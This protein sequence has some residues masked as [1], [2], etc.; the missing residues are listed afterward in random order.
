MGRKPKVEK[1]TITVV[2]N[3]TAISVILHPPKPPRR[4]W[5]AYWSGLTTS[6][7]TGQTRFDEAVRAVEGMLRNGG[8]RGEVAD[9]VL[10]DEEFE[11]I[12]RAHYGRKQD[13]QAKARAEKSLLATLEAM[14]AFKDI[15]G[16]SPI[17]STT[18]DDCAAFQRKALSLPRN[19]R[20]DYPK[21]K[22]DGVATLSPNTVLKWSRCLQAAFQRSCHNAGRKCV[23]GVVSE[24]KLLTSNPW[25]QFSWIE[26]TI[27]AKRRFG[28]DEL[29]SIL[30]YFEGDWGTVPAA[31][32]FAKVSLWIWGRRAEVARL[33]WEDLRI[34]GTEYH[35]DF[36]GKR[37]VRKWARI[38]NRL[39]QELIEARTD[40][41]YVFAAFTKQLRH[42][43][44][45]KNPGVE[46][47]VRQDY[48]PTAIGWWFHTKLAAWAGKNG[49]KH[50]T[51]HAFRKTAL[52]FARRGEDRNEAVAHDARIS[53][54][55][56]IRHYVD[57][58]DEELRQ[59]SNRTYY[60]LLAGLS[61][62]VARRYGYD[63]GSEPS[64]L[65]LRLQTAIN[66]QD[67]KTA[68]EIAK[69]LAARQEGQATSA[70]PLP[71]AGAGL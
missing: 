70:G 29:I 49:R 42:H 62:E 21:R 54:A 4:A 39:Y 52:Q 14:A 69:Q 41:P 44:K 55:V 53:R 31:T 30:D 22:R 38:P 59:G 23:R 33:A 32:L 40:S 8:K 37:G 60:R 24:S 9:T 57:E 61:P 67:W 64:E 46:S 34:V 50:A 12:Q 56:M 10:S 65:Q 3:G 15:T 66:T 25:M 71:I 19:W 16:V 63:V 18:A 47:S 68:G 36:I 28:D 26:G 11:A 43:Y 48:A 5:F 45:G 17:A 58:T 27:P 7:S 35:F 1:R 20:C 6:K 13:A 2:V 51:H